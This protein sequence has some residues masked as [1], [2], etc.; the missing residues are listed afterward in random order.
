MPPA[1]TLDCRSPRL[2]TPATLY[3]QLV[4]AVMPSGAASLLLLPYHAITPCRR[5]C[6][7]RLILL[8]RCYFLRLMLLPLFRRRHLPAASYAAAIHAATFFAMLTLRYCLRW[9]YIR[10][11]KSARWRLIRH[12][13]ICYDADDMPPRYCCCFIISHASAPDDAC[14]RRHFI[15]LML[16]PTMSRADTPRR[17]PLFSTPLYFASCAMPPATLDVSL[18]RR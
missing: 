12:Y 3:Y 8:L 6:C 9:R 13:A 18:L 7:L 1:A 17:Q 15:S 14:R 16:M 4:I 10:Y 5:C 11:F 2:L